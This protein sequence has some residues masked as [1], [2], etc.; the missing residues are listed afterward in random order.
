[1]P[2]SHSSLMVSGGKKAPLK[3]DY[4]AERSRKRL[5]IILSR[6]VL[7]LDRLLTEGVYSEDDIRRTVEDAKGII[8]LDGGD[9]YALAA[10]ELPR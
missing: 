7:H 2:K 9:L 4:T 10:K 8:S 5:A 1:M 6:C 3:R